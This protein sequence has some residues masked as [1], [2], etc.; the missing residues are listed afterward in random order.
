MIFFHR[1][2]KSVIRFTVRCKENELHRKYKG[3]EGST[4]NASPPPILEIEQ[5]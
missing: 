4:E 3:F 1:I 2:E 5:N